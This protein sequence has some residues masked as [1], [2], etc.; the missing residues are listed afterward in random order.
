MLCRDY[1]LTPRSKQFSFFIVSEKPLYVVAI[2]KNC[3]K[4]S[5]AKHATPN[6]HFCSTCQL[7]ANRILTVL[8]L[9]HFCTGKEGHGLMVNGYHEQCLCQCFHFIICMSWKKNKDK[10]NGKGRRFC[11]RGRMSSIPCR[12]SYFALDDLNYR[13]KCN[14]MICMKRMNS[15]YSSKSS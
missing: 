15:Y 8:F 13:M 9:I 2:L 11:L 12:A 3:W 6:R 7:F 5:S 4:Q 14:I 10:R 1:I